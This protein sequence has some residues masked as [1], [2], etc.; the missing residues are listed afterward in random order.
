[1]CLTCAIDLMDWQRRTAAAVTSQLVQ[2][3]FSL[4]PFGLIVPLKQLEEQCLTDPSTRRA[5]GRLFAEYIEHSA[6]TNN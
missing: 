1:M 6:M 3:S 4:T 2:F 5:V